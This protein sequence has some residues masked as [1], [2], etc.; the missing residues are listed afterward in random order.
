MNEKFIRKIIIILSSILAAAIVF[1]ATYCWKY[2][3][4]SA[5]IEHAGDSGLTELVSRQRD[6][7]EQL[8]SDLSGA[9]DAVE[10][11]AGRAESLEQSIQRALT[12]S[13]RADDEFAQLTAAMGSA[14]GTIKDTIDRQQRI[15]DAIKR[16][17]ELNRATKTELGDRP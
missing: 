5:T 7:I 11:A 9:R 17:E 4:L 1:G 12:I 10:S 2:Y 13:E 3:S 15:N 8:Q 6:T 16:L 14:G